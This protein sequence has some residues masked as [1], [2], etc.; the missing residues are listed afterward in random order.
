MKYILLGLISIYKRLISP[1]FG[2]NCRY[3]PTC[4]EYSYTAIELYGIIKGSK[5]ALRRIMSCHPGNPGGIDFVPGSDAEKRYTE[6]ENLKS[7]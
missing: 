6:E 7:F 5:I 1:I 4:S 3:Y 2:N